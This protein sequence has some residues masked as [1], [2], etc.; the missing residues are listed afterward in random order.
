MKFN[1]PGATMG[2]GAKLLAVA[3]AGEQLQG[4]SVV[5]FYKDVCR[6]APTNNNTAY[7]TASAHL[8]C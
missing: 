7:R 2:A 8:V 3:R 4:Q 6:T 5:R 1:Y